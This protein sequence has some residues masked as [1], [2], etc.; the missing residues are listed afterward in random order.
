MQGGWRL[1][2]VRLPGWDRL[3]R[4]ETAFLLVAQ[5]FMSIEMHLGYF[6]EEDMTEGYFQ[7]GTYRLRLDQRGRMQAMTLIGAYADEEDGLEYA[8]PGETRD[9]QVSFR[10]N[11]LVLRGENDRSELVF[12]RLAER[13]ERDFFGR[14]KPP[15]EDDGQEA[16]GGGD[17]R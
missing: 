5:E 4:Q 16:G 6:V 12:T 9:F 1:A 2:S 10:G 7:S 13:Y 17:G 8:S 11:E 14:S 3:H 15:G